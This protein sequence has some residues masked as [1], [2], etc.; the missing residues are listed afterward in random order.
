MY[1][2]LKRTANINNYSQ[3]SKDYKFDIRNTWKTRTLIGGV[4]D[5]TTLSQTF[6]FNNETISD[7]KV[8]ASKLCN[9]F[10]TIGQKYANEIPQPS[11]TYNHYL[12]KSKNK[13]NQ[14]TSSIPLT[15]VKFQNL[16]S[17]SNHKKVVV[18]IISA[19][20]Y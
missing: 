19:Q 9:Y 17:H 20:F 6:T 13:R 16:L 7:G 12:T 4:N 11:H 2:T 18:V 8:T 15:L 5:K 1:D 14:N 3:L 10:A